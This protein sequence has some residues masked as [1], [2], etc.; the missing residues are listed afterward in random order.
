MLEHSLCACG[1]VKAHVHS[2]HLMLL[3][4]KQRERKGIKEKNPFLSETEYF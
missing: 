4:T 2:L 1:V 3:Y